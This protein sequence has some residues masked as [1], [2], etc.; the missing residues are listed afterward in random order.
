[1]LSPS[2]TRTER[3]LSGQS[4]KT[5]NA[6]SGATI[7]ARVAK[8]LACVGLGW[9]GVALSPTGHQLAV[10]L[11]PFRRHQSNDCFEIIIAVL[12]CRTACWPTMR[13]LRARVNVSVNWVCAWQ[14][15]HT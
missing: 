7:V 10:Y 11:G 12:H 4:T 15:M 9:R 8:S 2:S 3:M 6:A 14:A 1:M 5:N 13:G